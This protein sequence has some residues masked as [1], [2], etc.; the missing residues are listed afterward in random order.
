MVDLLRIY[1]VDA[2]SRSVTGVVA[3]NRPTSG[4]KTEVTDLLRA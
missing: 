2:P 4:R 3:T 1:A